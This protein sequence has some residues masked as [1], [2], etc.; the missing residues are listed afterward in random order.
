[1]KNALKIFI[2]R[3]FQ[4]ITFRDILFKQYFCYETLEILQSTA[5]HAIH[6]QFDSSANVLEIRAV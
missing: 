4:N 5:R 3:G 6:L 2:G 1:M